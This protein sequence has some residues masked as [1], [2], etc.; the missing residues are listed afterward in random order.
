V[1]V[2]PDEADG[3]ILRAQVLGNAS[4]RACGDGVV[5]TENYWGGTAGERLLDALGG[6]V[7][8]VGDL[9][10]EW[11]AIVATTFCLRECDGDIATVGDVVA[12]SFELGFKPGYTQGGGAHVD[13]A[14]ALAE[15]EGDADDF[16]FFCG[17]W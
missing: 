15:V 13:S 14:A 7:R 1:R 6:A 2:D 8:A 9:V 10:E 12:E 5:A 16:D 4:D 3:F 11:R 17:M